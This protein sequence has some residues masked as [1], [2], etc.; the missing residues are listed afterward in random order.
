[1]LF[2]LLF[3]TVVA[4]SCASVSHVKKLRQIQEQF[5]SAASLENQLKTDPLSADARIL[6]SGESNASY[7]LVLEDITKLIDAKGDALQTDKLLGS[8]YTLKAL[9]E[10]RLGEYDAAVKTSS[11]VTDENINLFPRDRALITALRGLIKND[12]GFSHM[13]KKDHAYKD[14][15]TLFVE[16]V[17][18]INEGRLA[19]PQENSIRTY[20]TMGKLAALKNWLD[21][22]GNPN[23]FALA[24]P[25]DL[26]KADEQKEWC[27]AAKTVWEVFV[28]EMDLL[29][30]PEAAATKKWWGNRLALPA[31]CQ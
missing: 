4:H 14:L 13:M 24:V 28:Q 25:A 6:F 2:A 26:S 7:R 15:K 29:G 1:M 5:N 9:T 27:N 30:T 12:Q 18:D 10:W 21:L 16:S 11:V 31:A 23:Q 3:I 22:F 19:V 8:A 17:H 20:L